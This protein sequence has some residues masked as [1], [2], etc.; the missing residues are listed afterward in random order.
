MLG[1]LVGIALPARAGSGALGGVLAANAVRLRVVAL[2]FGAVRTGHAIPSGFSH[3][4]AS[5]S[6]ANF[7]SRCNYAKPA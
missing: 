3:V 7:C 5:K 2:A 4:S 6:I 1:E